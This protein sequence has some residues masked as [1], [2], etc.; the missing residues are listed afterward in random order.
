[1]QGGDDGPDPSVTFVADGK[2]VSEVEYGKD[3]SSLPPSKVPAVPQKEGYTS[4][5]S[6]Y[7]LSGGDVTVNAVYSP[8]TYYATFTIGSDKVAQVPFTV[9][10]KEIKAPDAPRKDG[11]H[12]EWSSHTV[13]ARSFEI[14]G[15]YV[16]TTYKAT[17][18]DTKGTAGT[19]DDISYVRYFTVNTAA[20][21]E[22]AISAKAG[23]TTAWQNYTLG[24]GDITVRS[25][26][27][28][29]T[30]KAT[31]IDTKGTAGTSD[32]TTVAVRYFNVA[33][34]SISEPALPAKAGYKVEWS[35]YSLGASDITVKAV[36][37]LIYYKATFVDTKATSDSSDDTTVAVRYFSVENP[38]VSEPPVPA[39]KGF[40]VT[41]PS[42]TLGTSDITVKTTYVMNVYTATFVDTKG[43]VSP[44]DDKVVATRNF[45]VYSTSISEPA[46]PSKV[47]YNVTW[48][49]YTLGTADITVKTVY[50][51]I[52]YKAT[53]VDT[54]NTSASADDT[55]AGIMYFTVNT[56]KL[57]PQSFVKDASLRYY[58][59]D[60]GFVP[61]MHQNVTLRS[62]YSP[63]YADVNVTLV[64]HF[65]ESAPISLYVDG[66]VYG[67]Y[68]IASGGSRTV[69][70]HEVLK[71]DSKS[72]S[73]FAS[74]TAGGK[75]VNSGTVTETLVNKGQF[76][77]KFVLDPG[78]HTANIVVNVF[79]NNSTFES[80]VTNFYFNGTK[81]NDSEVGSVSW[82]I[83]PKGTIAVMFSYT[84]SQFDAA[85]HVT[86]DAQCKVVTWIDENSG[87]ADV[88]M[89]GSETAYTGI[90]SV[91]RA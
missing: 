16:P 36:Y 18:I 34:G 83:D 11:Y 7:S 53:F 21:S 25:V 5:W 15:K 46:V 1:M 50:S 87:S 70:V 89:H 13:Q 59:V 72:M 58:N 56:Q 39:K 4:R 8:I 75:T 42:Y 27:T 6:S 3:D 10:T 2:V 62:S 79:N 23:Y 88:T 84:F 60:W 43:T 20:V 9:E 33:S 82:H 24:L 37:S 66:T 28:P 80:K 32:D 61:G 69:T 17:F 68:T 44:S 86:L 14:S 63:Y 12:V 41:W 47:G 74:G 81:V 35:R 51:I 67:T 45:N 30:Y 54:H 52:S 78:A 76:S 29:I 48:S 90:I 38:T 57:E 26:Y 91:S 40:T 64:N 71:S 85:V 22:P 19:S 49:G 65:D 31:F 77:E 73:L 55:I